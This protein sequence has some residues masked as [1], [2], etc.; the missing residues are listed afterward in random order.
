M[1]KR[2]S[3]PRAVPVAVI[4][5]QLLELTQNEVPTVR[6]YPASCDFHPTDSGPTRR[7]FARLDH[8]HAF[9][10]PG[11]NRADQAGVRTTDSSCSKYGFPQSRRALPGKPLRTLS[12]IALL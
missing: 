11:T 4:N 9:Q 8:P 7:P 6:R 3:P 10:T 12:A 1:T 2:R 5:P